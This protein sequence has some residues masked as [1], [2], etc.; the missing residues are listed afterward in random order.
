MEKTLVVVESPAKAKTIKKYLGSGYEVKASVGHIKDLPKNAPKPDKKQKGAK[1]KGA[2]GWNGP[3]LGVDVAHGFVPHYEVIPG[4]EKIIK[5]LRDS[6][7]K[8]GKVLLATDPDREGEAIAWHLSEELK[9]PK[10]K[11]YRVLF[12]EL[13]ERTIKEAVASPRRLDENKYNAQQ[14][15]RILDRIVGYQL[16]PLLWDKVQYGLSAGRVQSVTLKL[17]VD[18]KNAIDMFAPQEFWSIGATLE[19]DSPPAFPAKLIEY[20]GAKV[21]IRRASE[22]ADLSNQAKQHPFVVVDVKRRERSRKPGPPFITS[23]LQQEASRRLRMAA[24]RTMRIAQQLYEGIELGDQ[25]AVGLITYM[26]TDSPRI[27]PEALDAVRSHIKETYGPNYL[28]AKPNVYRGKKTAQEAHEA[29]RPTSMAFP[30]EKAA[31][32]L[33]RNQLALYR[34]IWD[35]FVASQMAAAVFDQTTADIRSGDLLF[36]S[37]GSVMRFDGFLRVYLQEEVSAQSDSG[38]DEPEKDE[39]SSLLPPLEAG[40]TMR[41]LKLAPRQHFTQPPPQFTEASLIKELEDLG[42]GRPSTYAE[43]VSTIQ[44]RKYVEVNEKKFTPTVLGRVIAGLLQGSFPKLLDERFTALMESDL[45]NIEEGN[46]SWTETLEGFYQPFQSDLQKAG[47]E[48]K[49]VKRE[50][51]STRIAC[52]QCGKELMARSGRYG[53]FFGCSAYPGCDFTANMGREAAGAKEA[54]PTDEKCP[55]CGAMMVIRQGKAGPFLSCSTYPDCKTARPLSTGVKCPKCGS[56][57]LLQRKSR[58][59]GKVFYSCSRYPE[60]DY[61]VWNKPVQEPCPNPQCAFPIME[62]KV[63]KKGQRFVQCPQCKRKT[64][65]PTA[66]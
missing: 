11:V 57:E 62:E 46:V 27:A 55:Q 16:S 63:D 29:I 32:F 52:P 9:T 25:G 44:K 28:P 35:R 42:I 17:I 31:R 56:G 33:D 66:A 23:T 45:D 21:E 18:R 24:S 58:K 4:K 6:A 39:G 8:A 34:L 48:M 15:R 36:R 12:N 59:R 50:G 49:S 2:A 1:T 40:Q 26:R 3:V 38:K 61:S 22:A 54:I 47:R 65:I 60:C 64:P 10:D 19:G 51:L 14:A 43:I 7:Q 30:P 37:S 13:T 53:L 41:L 5:E 20:K